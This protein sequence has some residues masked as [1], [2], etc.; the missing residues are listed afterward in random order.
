MSYTAVQI[1]RLYIIC[2]VVAVLAIGVMVLMEWDNRKYRRQEKPEATQQDIVLSPLYTDLQNRFNTTTDHL[3]AL[4]IKWSNLNA[5]YLT[6]QNQA[7]D[8]QQ[9]IDALTEE[10]NT[11]QTKLTQ[12]TIASESL[13]INELTHQN[14]ILN[15]QIQTLRKNLNQ[16]ISKHNTAISERDTLQQN[17]IR[18]RSDCNQSQQQLNELK[19]KYATLQKERQ[20]VKIPTAGSTPVPASSSPD[21]NSLSAQ[22][23]VRLLQSQILLIH[24][25]IATSEK[26]LR[27]TAELLSQIPIPDTESHAALQSSIFHLQDKI[28]N[29][30]SQLHKDTQTSKQI[31][32]TPAIEH[33]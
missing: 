11:L 28:K 32:P 21:E 26:L 20:T 4:K 18:A 10:R 13:R 17:L 27:E 7:A 30:L 12:K 29:T 1:R 24:Y 6:I 22:A 3:D 33:P 5:A 19:N 2:G 16:S 9:R 23:R 25:D 31:N 14:S 15:E 8:Y